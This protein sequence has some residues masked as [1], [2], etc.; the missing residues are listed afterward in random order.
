[1]RRQ[2]RANA[3][4]LPARGRART[5]CSI[6]TVG[7]TK[8]RCR[9]GRRPETCVDAGTAASRSASTLSACGVSSWTTTTSGSASRTISSRRRAE[10][11]RNETLTVSTLSGAEAAVDASPA[12]GK[13]GSTGIALTAPAATSTAQAPQRRRAAASASSTAATAKYCRR[14]CVGELEHPRQ[15]RAERQ[16]AHQG[17]DGSA[18]PRAGDRASAS[19]AGS[20]GAASALPQLQHAANCASLS[21]PHVAQ[22]HAAPRAAGRDALAEELRGARLRRRR[23]VSRARARHRKRADRRCPPPSSPFL[24]TQAMP[25]WSST[26]LKC[27]VSGNELP[28]QTR[29]IIG[30][31]SSSGAQRAQEHGRIGAALEHLDERR[32]HDDAVGVRAEQRDLIGAPHAEAGADGQARGRLDGREVLRRLGRQRRRRP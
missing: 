13:Y 23:R 20:A 18:Q 12:S 30:L 27:V 1:M 29:F 2:A 32:A 8:G 5:S 10:N 15:P 24:M 16:H 11:C 22:R 3:P 19:Y 17:H 31:S 26:F 25:A 4:R 9:A 6:R 21:S 28:L 14:K 7:A